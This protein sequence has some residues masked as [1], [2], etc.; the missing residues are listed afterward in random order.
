MII[1]ATPLPLNRSVARGRADTEK[2]DRPGRSETLD[3]SLL[4]PLG[5]LWPASRGRPARKEG[6][7]VL[8]L[9]SRSQVRKRAL[10]VP[11]GNNERISATL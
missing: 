8:S 3:Y 1:K 10:M 2:V 11:A 5:V 6:L 4:S 9:V 7:S